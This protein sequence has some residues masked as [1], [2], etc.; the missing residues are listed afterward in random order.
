MGKGI[1]KKFRRK[2]ITDYNTKKREIFINFN[3]LCIFEHQTNAINPQT[4]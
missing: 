3:L 4:K 2:A 1:Q